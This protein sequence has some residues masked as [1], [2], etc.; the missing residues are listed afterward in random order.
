MQDDTDSQYE[1]RKP[2]DEFADPLSRQT[3]LDNNIEL[4][5]DPCD[6]KTINR[7]RKR[8]IKLI[9]NLQK[10]N[11]GL[12]SDTDEF[13]FFASNIAAQLRELPLDRALKLQVNIQNLVAN[14]RIKFF[15][16]LKA[17]T[18]LIFVSENDDG[19]HDGIGS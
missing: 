8:A 19:E 4:A 10:L 14:E 17:E 12:D 6:D 15:E 5:I 18:E 7:P 1:L 2:K 16:D 11:Q 3:H 9:N 13:Q